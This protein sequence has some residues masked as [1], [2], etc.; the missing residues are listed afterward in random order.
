MPSLKTVSVSSA[1]WS[2]GCKEEAGSSDGS[3]SSGPS[4]DLPIPV[5][6][7]GIRVRATE[8]DGLV[9]PR[10]RREGEYAYY[11]GN[12]FEQRAA[13]VLNECRPFW[14]GASVHPDHE[15]FLVQQISDDQYVVE[16]TALDLELYVNTNDLRD[17]R[18]DLPHLFLQTLLE[19]RSPDDPEVLEGASKPIGD[20]V[21]AVLEDRLNEALPYPDGRTSDADTPR[22]FR[23]FLYGNE[24]EILDDYLA[25][26]ISLRCSVLEN[27]TYFDFR[28]WYA[29]AAQRAHRER[30]PHWRQAFTLDLLH[31]ELPNLFEQYFEQEGDEE[32]ILCTEL[33]LN[34]VSLKRSKK[35]EEPPLT[36]E[37][38]AAEPRDFKRVIPKPIIVSS[39]I[40]GQTAKTLLDTG[41]LSD[42]ITPNFAQHLGAKMFPLA[43]QIPLAL[44]V[45][46]SRAKIGSGCIAEIDYQTVREKRYFDVAVMNYDVILGTPFLYQHKVHLSLNPTTVVIGSARCLPLDGKQA[47]TLESCAVDLFED[48]LEAARQEL[49]EYAESICKDAS[50]SPLP[51]L[52]AI[53]HT[54]PLKDESKIYHWRPSK[55]PDALRELW[56]EKRDAYLKS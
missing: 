15:F 40:N 4:G 45:K 32:L 5:V 51:P 29:H 28:D 47:K 50:D 8:V 33:E 23:C 13:A 20:A 52:R 1:D 35:H 12:P 9:L 22:R 21:A 10:T 31:D 53:N 19:H 43:K 7:D 37:R 39:K 46:G 42:F 36:L 48:R 2:P 26:S 38:N 44:A 41:S 56:I 16:N 6:D 11:F 18:F 54:I 17:P 34:A 30:L 25:I 24:V 27:G 3:S 55:C 14:Q 49:R